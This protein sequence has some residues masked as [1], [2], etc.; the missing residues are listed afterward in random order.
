M[1]RHSTFFRDAYSLYKFTIFSEP[2]LGVLTDWEEYFNG[3]SSLLWIFTS[4]IVHRL[5]VFAFF[6]RCQE[7]STLFCA[8]TSNKQIGWKREYRQFLARS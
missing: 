1:R 3:L 7:P 6:Y 2:L 8:S 5:S 4:N